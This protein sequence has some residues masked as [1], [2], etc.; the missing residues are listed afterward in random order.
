MFTNKPFESIPN[1]QPRGLRHTYILQG[2]EQSDKIDMAFVAQNSNT[3]PIYSVRR[4][5]KNGRRCRIELMPE[6]TFAI[7]DWSMQ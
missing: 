1:G 3:Y 4:V 2:Y 6:G 7:M 5:T